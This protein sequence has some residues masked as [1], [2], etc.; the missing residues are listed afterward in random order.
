MLRSS[1]DCFRG[2]CRLLS[3]FLAL[4]SALIDALGGDVQ[5]H[6]HVSA[7]IVSLVRSWL[8]REWDNTEEGHGNSRKFLESANWCDAMLQPMLLMVGGTP[9]R[10]KHT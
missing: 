4:G 1:P 8:Q 6:H 3:V 7:A 10:T 2:F 5:C 9:Y